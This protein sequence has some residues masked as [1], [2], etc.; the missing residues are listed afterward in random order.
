MRSIE[1]LQW[2][3]QSRRSVT[4]SRKYCS[5]VRTLLDTDW[6]LES[7]KQRVED[8][9]LL[10]LSSSGE[11]P[12]VLPSPGSDDGVVNQQAARSRAPMITSC[13]SITAW[14][15]NANIVE[16]AMQCLV[17]IGLRIPS[18]FFTFVRSTKHKAL[19]GSLVATN[20]WTE[21]SAPWLA[22]RMGC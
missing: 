15:P 5:R 10:M 2:R 3:S 7:V 17:Y 21:Y 19:S 20:S 18:Y 8:S 12:K 13:S 22:C 9:G 6:L 4:G 16:V 11:S 14:K 1:V